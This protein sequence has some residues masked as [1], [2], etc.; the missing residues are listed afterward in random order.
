MTETLDRELVDL[1]RAV[2]RQYIS[3]ADTG[4][5][6]LVQKE[7][8]N[9]MVKK[10]SRV[11]ARVDGRAAN[12]EE[13]HAFGVDVTNGLTEREAEQRE[14]E[15]LTIRLAYLNREG[16]YTPPPALTPMEQR[17][18]QWTEEHYREGA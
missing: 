2:R 14:R 18:I 1:L 5:N 10:V 9:H 7:A 4:G 3:M 8:A 13:A 17:S 6:Y 12:A 11:L 15:V 16:D